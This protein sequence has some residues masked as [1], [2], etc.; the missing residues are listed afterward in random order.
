[1]YFDYAVAIPLEKGKIITKK[2][3]NAVY[4]LYQHRSDIH[5]TTSEFLL[6]Q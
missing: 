1:M 4:V 5:L 2:K 3:G 6:S